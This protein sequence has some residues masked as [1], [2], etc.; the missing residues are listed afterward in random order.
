MAKRKRLT[1]PSPED[2]RPVEGAPETKSIFPSYPLGVAPS[3]TSARRAPIADMAGAAAATAALSEVSAELEAARAEGRLVQALPLD[4]IDAGHLVR[5]R[6][7]GSVA[8]DEMQSL[9]ESLRSR[10]Q[11][12]P[13]EVMEVGQ[14]RYGLISGWRR[15]T[16]LRQL[17][18]ETGDAAFATVHALVRRPDTAVDAYVAMVEENEIRVGLSY[19][20][21]AQIVARSVEEGVYATEKQALNGLFGTASRAKRSKIKSFLPVV[22][23]LGGTLRFPTAIGERLG[24]KLSAQ[25]SETGFATWLKDQLIKATPTTAEAEATVL[26]T[27]K[28]QK[29]RT[30]QGIT[31]PTPDLKTPPGEEITPGLWLHRDANGLHLSG[32]DLDSIESRLRSA[33]NP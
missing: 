18:E 7:T 14:G 11:Q 12:T 28:S 4:T 17:F 3:A 20:E 22:E 1:P 8:D 31:K 2:V 27:P 29:S 16:A 19:F 13:I 23:A 30:G 10:G 21:R 26:N 24:L 33:L 25:L 6:L 32:A 15:L 5:D 9:V